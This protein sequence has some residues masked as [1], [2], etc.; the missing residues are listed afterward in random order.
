MTT[1]CTLVKNLPDVITESDENVGL[2]PMLEQKWRKEGSYEKEMS[3]LNV[4][5]RENW[6]SERQNITL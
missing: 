6:I 3:E 2:P 1:A 4:F 5:F